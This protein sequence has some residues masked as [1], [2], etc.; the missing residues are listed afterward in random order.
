M[1]RAAARPADDRSADRREHRRRAGVQHSGDDLDQQQR[2][3][4]SH[5]EVGDVVA[6]HVRRRAP[7]SSPARSSRS[8]ASCTTGA[9]SSASRSRRTETSRS[10]SRSR[11]RPSRTSSSTTT[12]PPCAPASHRSKNGTLGCP[13]RRT[14]AERRHIANAR[15]RQR[16]A[17]C[18]RRGA[19][20]AVVALAPH[21]ERTMRLS[22]WMLAVLVPLAACDEL[23]RS[24]DGSRRPRERHLRAAAERRSKC[25]RRRALDVGR[26][27]QRPR[28][29]VQCL[30]T[31]S[32]P[33]PPGYF[34]RPRRRR[35]STTRAYQK[36]QYYVATR[37]A[38]G[39]EIAQSNTVT[40]DLTANRLP[41][42]QS[43]ASISLN[44]AIQLVWAGNAVAAS[45][46]MFDHYLV[47][48]TDYDA[49]ARRVHGQLGA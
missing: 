11:S 49:S 5:A 18:G 42:P 10:T 25:T 2:Q 26:P 17:I 43:L 12:A 39:D 23:T 24:R 28:E 19:L 27:A 8:S 40:I 21:P 47:Y 35:R 36:A 16:V 48:S 4:Q 30:R 6:D 31:T 9:R 46:S 14:T 38:N 45:P 15:S 33:A 29:L 34:G 44:G 7:S 41:A 20:D 37:D 1:S 13:P 32:V 3:L 22:R